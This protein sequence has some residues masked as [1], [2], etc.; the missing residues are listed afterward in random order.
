MSQ[1]QNHQVNVLVV[2]PDALSR[3]NIHEVMIADG[4]GCR[5]VGSSAAA[6]ASAREKTPDLLI[7]DMNLSDGT[8]IGLLRQ[9]RSIV[10]C[11]V[12]FVSD[13]RDAEMVRYARNAGATFYLSKPFDADVLMELVDKALW[14]PHLVQRHVD[15]AA[16]A[17]HQVKAPTFS[18]NTNVGAE[19]GS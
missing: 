12:I 5:A 1:V 4:Y 3:G 15:S 8:G 11:P 19:Q 2:D 18:L 16:H 14:M 13:S 9:L 17:A 6:L 10:D 7:S